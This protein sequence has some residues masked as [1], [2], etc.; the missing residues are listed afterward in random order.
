MKGCFVQYRNETG[1]MPS[2]RIPVKIRIQP[3]GSADRVY[4]SSGTYR[5]S[6]LDNCLAESI[7]EIRFPPWEGEAK[8]YTYP[9]TL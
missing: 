9:F 6:S 5:D 4:I 3:S 1:S 2:G 7:M 8:N